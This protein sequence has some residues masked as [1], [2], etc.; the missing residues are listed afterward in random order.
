MFLES[1]LH[2][3]NESIKFQRRKGKISFLFFFSVGDHFSYLSF[4]CLKHVEKPRH[5]VSFS[6]FEDSEEA[7]NDQS[8]EH[9]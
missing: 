9:W 8:N 6:A 7:T 2:Q 4:F 3:E 1:V 5:N